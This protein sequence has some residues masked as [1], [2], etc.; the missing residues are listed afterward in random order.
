M[1]QIIWS[2]THHISRAL[3]IALLALVCTCGCAMTTRSQFTSGSSYDK[4]FLAA[5]Q[6]AQ[7]I[8]FAVTTASK[9]D[10]FISANQAVVMGTGTHTVLNAQ[11]S[12]NGKGV[13][14]EASIIP[15]PAM[16]GD[17]ASIMRNFES[18]LKSRV[19]DIQ[20]RSSS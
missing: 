13:T 9:S 16:M 10:G 11:I 19:P 7:A 3:A 17:V 12:R 1:K 6:S 2:E 18:E 5:Q 15:P 20:V 8:G 14:V 4:V